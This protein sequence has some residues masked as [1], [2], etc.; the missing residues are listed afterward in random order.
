MPTSF[1]LLVQST[2]QGSIFLPL[3]VTLNCLMDHLKTQKWEMDSIQLPP[4]HGYKYILV[5]ICL[6]SHWTEAFSGRQAAASSAAKVLLEK[7]IPTW[8]T[9]LKLNSD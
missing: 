5:M 8:R 6:F 9:P 3:P 1:V 2:T 4:S 7:I